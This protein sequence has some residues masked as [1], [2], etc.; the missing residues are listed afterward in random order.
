MIPTI[1]RHIAT[2]STATGPTIP[3]G[4]GL[5]VIIV[6]TQFKNLAAAG[7][8]YRRVNVFNDPAGE[9]SL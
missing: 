4:G 3:A 5:Q 1:Y 2:I 7:S 9:R 8:Y 6:G